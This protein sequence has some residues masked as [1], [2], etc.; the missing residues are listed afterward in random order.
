MVFCFL[1]CLPCY[2]IGALCC[3]IASLCVDE[4]AYVIMA[5]GK[6]KK[7]AFLKV[8]DRV[9]TLNEKGE[10][11]CTPVIMFA[12]VGNSKSKPQSTF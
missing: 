10:L 6:R 7:I 1:C 12:H 9:K 11:V 4:Q 8:G 3:I 5:N 2:C